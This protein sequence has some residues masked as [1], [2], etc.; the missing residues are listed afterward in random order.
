MPGTDEAGSGKSLRRLG[1]VFH[2]TRFEQ[3]S[4]H[5]D[6]IA[7]LLL[8][9]GALA[10][11][12]GIY[13]QWFWRAAEPPTYAPLL[14]VAGAGLIAAYA[15]Y[16]PGPLETLVVGELGVGKASDGRVD[17]MAWYEFEEVSLSHGA[18]LLKTAGKPL[19]LPLKAY[20][21]AAR[22]II[23]EALQRIPK[24]V[25]IGEDEMA[26]LGPPKADAGETREAEP[27]QV[28][29]LRCRNSNK[30]LTIERDVRMC[31]RCG[32]LYHRKGVPRR[33]NECRRILKTG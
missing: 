3:A 28:T 2:E 1:E 31:A 15:I 7:V 17:R 22:V 25:A 13:A 26:K 16:A 27:P 5:R 20:P 11:G 21:A 14:L 19:H 9:I 4:S 23:A 8:S 10:L 24:R 18:L 6:L 32:A 30:P 29:E 12:A 33:C